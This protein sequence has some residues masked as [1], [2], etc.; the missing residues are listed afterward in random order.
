MCA[1]IFNLMFY[2]DTCGVKDGGEG[3]D[4]VVVALVEESGLDARGLMN[5]FFVVGVVAV[6]ALGRSSDLS[7]SVL[8]DLLEDVRGLSYRSVGWGLRSRW[9]WR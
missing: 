9:H 7:E 5:S 2:D 1:V 3:V 8:H 6:A 4:D